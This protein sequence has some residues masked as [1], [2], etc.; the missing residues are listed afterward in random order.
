VAVLLLVLLD[1]IMIR[2]AKAMKLHVNYAHLVP[3]A[4][5]VVEIVLMCAVNVHLEHTMINL[6]S[7]DYHHN[8]IKLCS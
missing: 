2:L 3:I 6:V 7:F 8:A 1:R 4:Q 5:Q